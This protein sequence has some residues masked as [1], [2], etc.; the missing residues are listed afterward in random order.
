MYIWS[1]K[2]YATT[3]VCLICVLFPVAAKSAGNSVLIS[4]DG[5]L[6]TAEHVIAGCTSLSAVSIG[7]VIT[8]AY[9]KEDDLALLKSDGKINAEPLPLSMTGVRPGDE[10][11]AVGYPL[12]G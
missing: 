2:M 12:Q 10:V 7:P 3:F 11:I 8:M 6:I 9:D 4:Q 5:Y 1:M